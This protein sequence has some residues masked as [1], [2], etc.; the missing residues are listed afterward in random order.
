MSGIIGLILLGVIVGV[1]GAILGIGG[2]IIMVPV[3]TFFFGMPIHNAIAVSLAAITAN[4]MS[5]SSVYLKNGMANMNMGIALSIASA[6]GAAAGSKIAVRLPQD[7]VMIILGL[8]QI[9]M[10][11]LTYMKMKKGVKP[12]SVSVSDKNFF[13]G[14]YFDKAADNIIRYNPVRAGYN[15]FFSVFSGVFSGL[16][17]AGGGAMLIPGMNIISNMPIKAA[18]ATSSFII[19]FTA[20]A[21]SAVYIQ[22]GYLEAETACSIIF[23][24]FAGTAI[25]MRFFSKITDK[26]VSYLL[27]IL[28]LSVAANMIYKGITA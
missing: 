6:I 5:A 25:S 8:I 23:G 15:I 28:L 27:I 1:L 10:A 18:T 14:E 16:S 24:I 22:A 7:T 12:H 11:Y 17:G 9:L 20:A 2:G 19:G 13:Y 3:L 26:K 21:G 4:S